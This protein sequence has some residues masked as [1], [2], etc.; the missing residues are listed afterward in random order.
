M[1]L[2][3]VEDRRARPARF[4]EV[5][6]GVRG[7]DPGHVLEEPAA[8]D[9]RDALDGNLLQQRQHRLHV[10]ARGLQQHL[11]QRA[12]VERLVELGSGDG[13]DLANQREAIG[14][15]A[16]RGEPDDGV[17]RSDRGPVDDEFLFHQA[18]RESR[19]VVF[20]RIVEPG[21]FGGL[22]ADE[23]AS[24]LLAAGG[25]A[26]HDVGG[27]LHAQLSAGEVVEEEHGLGAGDEDVVHAHRHE[28]DADGVVLLHPEGELQLGSH[29]VRAGDH[30][31]IPELL[32]HLDQGAETPEVS[33]HLGAHRAPGE[34]LDALDQLVARVDVDARVA[35]G[36]GVGGSGHGDTSGRTSR[37]KFYRIDPQAA[38]RRPRIGRS[39]IRRGR[40]AVRVQRTR[41]GP[42]GRTSS[43]GPRPRCG[44]RSRGRR[45]AARRSR[46]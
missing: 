20:V 37:A 35:V 27:H 38:R 5:R 10:D 6:G 41:S 18:H 15:R 28:I 26:L 25:N 44:A 8:G 39:P 32:R 31:G 42:G 45:A 16:A 19:E 46:W 43:A 17:A 40:S 12:P 34:G 24:G 23:G 29:A 2:Q 14:V 7:Q 3:P 21:H 33:Q 9:M 22:A 4:L 36:E 30:H 1:R 11:A 13:E